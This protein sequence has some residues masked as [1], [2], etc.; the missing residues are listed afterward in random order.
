MPKIRVFRPFSGN[1]LKS[2]EEM[3]DKEGS[4]YLT[5]DR[6]EFPNIEIT[7]EN[8]TTTFCDV[9]MTSHET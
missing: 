9:Y 1:F 2:W 3:G 6:N 4:G 7:L 5:N 8:I